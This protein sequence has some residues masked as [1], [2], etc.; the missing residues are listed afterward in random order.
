MKKIKSIIKRLLKLFPSKTVLAEIYYNKPDQ[1]LAD[2]KIIITGGSHGI[3]FSMARKFSDEGAQV[4]IAGRNEEALIKAANEIG[5]K[6]AILDLMKIENFDDFIMEADKI[7]GRVDC[8]VNNA[9]ISLHEKSFFNVTKETFDKQINTNFRGPF[10]LTQSYIRYLKSKNWCGNVLFVSSETGFTADFRPYGYT[11]AAV[12]SM[13]EGLAYLFA[14]DNIRINA[15]APGIT[16]TEMTGHSW[17]ENLYCHL[18]MTERAYL[19]EEVAEAACFLLSD[20]SGCISGQIIALNNGRTI[21]ARVK[22]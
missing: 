12:N 7:L 13:V 15:V 10:F 2:K 16:A 20:A 11:K 22:E 19:P 5:C 3:G 17:D 18:N 8:L 4:L 21:N 1:R 14:K 6:W 9:G